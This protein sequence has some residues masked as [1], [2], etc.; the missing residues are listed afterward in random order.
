MKGIS[1]PK[2]YDT[3]L[4]SWIALQAASSNE[5]VTKAHQKV[6]EEANTAFYNALERSFKVL[7]DEGAYLPIVLNGMKYVRCEHDWAQ[8]AKSY[9]TAIRKA[10]EITLS[11]RDSSL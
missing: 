11:V 8:I 6:L 3:A 10:S 4:R 1:S 7:K 5:P 2:K 9:E